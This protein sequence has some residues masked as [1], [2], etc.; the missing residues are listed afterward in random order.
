MIKRSISLA[1]VFALLITAG[2]YH[3]TQATV[4]SAQL[5]TGVLAKMQTAH[6][7]LRSMRTSMAQVRRNPQIGSVETDYGTLIYKPGGKGKSKMRIDYTRPDQKSVSVVGESLVFYQPRINQVLKTTLSK[8]AKG[9]TSSYSALVGLDSSLE[10][11]TR[12][13]NVEY[14][15]DELVNGKQATRLQ[16]I[17]KASGP[18]SRIELWVSNEFWLPVQYQMFERNGDSTLVKFTNMEINPNLADSVFN[19]NVPSGTKVVDKI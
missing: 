18:F 3:N 12:D 8:A 15:K 14:I 17:P 16:L 4:S 19:V 5:L 6:R 1:V 13:Y 9:K 11:L 7:S 2:I 10:S